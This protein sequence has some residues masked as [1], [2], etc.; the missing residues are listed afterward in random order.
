[1][2]TAI[3]GERI[4]GST[5]RTFGLTAESDLI[6]ASNAMHFQAA[7]AQALCWRGNAGRPPAQRLNN[8]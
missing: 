2:C 8:A 6:D 3:T 1:L 7:A 5:V 4:G